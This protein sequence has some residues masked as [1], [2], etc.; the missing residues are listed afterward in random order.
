MRLFETINDPRIVPNMY[1][2]ARIDG[3]NFSGL[4]RRVLKVKPFNEII[5]DAMI[6]S[7][8]HAMDCGFD[9]LFGFTQSDEISLLLDPKKLLFDGKIRK[10]NSLLSAEVSVTFNNEMKLAFKEFDHAVFDCRLIQLPSVD[11]VVDYFSWRVSDSIR[12]CLNAWCYYMFT[13]LM[14]QSPKVAQ[15]NIEKMEWVEKILRLKDHDIDFYELPP[16]QKTGTGI[17]WVR[18]KK[19]GYN[20]ITSKT[21]NVIRKTLYTQHKLPTNDNFRSFIRGFIS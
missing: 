13:K 1:V 7:A 19:D 6:K 9:V 10:F 2:I 14:K 11:L 16:W 4:T 18:Y 12:N 21:V 5:K 3:K 8:R 17:Y 15:S 20:P